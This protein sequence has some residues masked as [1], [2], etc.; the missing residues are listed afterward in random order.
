MRPH[1]RIGFN[2]TDLSQ[3]PSQFNFVTVTHPFDVGGYTVLPGTNNVNVLK[4]QVNMSG[5]V[6]V[7]NITQMVL[8]AKDA[9][10]NEVTSARLYY[11]EDD[12]TF[13]TNNLLGTLTAATGN[14]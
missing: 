2:E 11:T 8:G 1:F 6:G 7:P 3:L 13:N 5:Q 4:V 12:D 10:T 14:N 9:S